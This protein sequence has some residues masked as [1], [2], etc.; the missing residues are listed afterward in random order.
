MYACYHGAE[1]LRKIAARV[2]QL[3]AVLARGLGSLGFKVET[4]NFFDT[5]TRQSWREKPRKSRARL[6][7][8]G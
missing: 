1:G 4:A 3:T 6:R 2:H 7:R 5:Y 8:N